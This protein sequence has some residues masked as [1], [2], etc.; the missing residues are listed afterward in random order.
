VKR[1]APKG[2]TVYQDDNIVAIVTL[3]STN[4][5]T[6]NMAQLWILNKDIDP[7][8]AAKTGSDELICGDCKHRPS[9]M[10]T[11][12]VTLFHGP[13]GIWK[14]YHRG[15]YPFLQSS[16]Y[17]SVLSGKAIRLG[18][19]GDPAFV[20]YNILENLTAAAAG[21]TGYTHQWRRC[22]A[23]YRNLVMASVDTAAEYA[24]AKRKGYRTFRVSAT[25]Q[26]NS[27]TEITCPASS[28]KA[29]CLSC[30]L[31]CGTKRPH[32]KDITIKV[33]GA[34]AGSFNA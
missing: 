34:R 12:Y 9:N 25:G 11:C 2:F 20:P 19:Y 26:D 7:L 33:H 14:A 6:G 23:K 10:G 22:S 4:V 32:A 8:T 30:K 15:R 21:F 5:K 28:G 1:I 27:A 17:A 13:L 18:A 16:D 29:L 31:C 3:K 24:R